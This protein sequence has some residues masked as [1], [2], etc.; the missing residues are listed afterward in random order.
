MIKVLLELQ[1]YL[2]PDSRPL[3]CTRLNVQEREGLNDLRYAEQARWN[4]QTSYRLL[5]CISKENR[6]FGERLQNLNHILR[7]QHSKHPHFFWRL[8]H[9]L[10]W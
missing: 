1:E 7:A 3:A 6:S 8:Y 9:F 4:N 5:D 10:E 2:C